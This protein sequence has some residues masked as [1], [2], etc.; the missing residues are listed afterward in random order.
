MK[1]LPGFTIEDVELGGCRLDVGY[2]A[3]CPCPSLLYIPNPVEKQSKNAQ[4]IP[5]FRMMSPVEISRRIE[6]CDRTIGEF[7][8][9]A[10]GSVTKVSLSSEE[11]SKGMPVLL[12]MSSVRGFTRDKELAR[13]L[14]PS[15]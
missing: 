15:L 2:L 1:I 10:A 4:M 7:P 5:S 6:T 11:D 3:E 9:S 13:T 8:K 14:A 12:P